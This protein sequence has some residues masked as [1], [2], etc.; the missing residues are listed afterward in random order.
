MP[1]RDVHLSAGAAAGTTYATYLAWDQPGPHVVAEAIGGV[2]GGIVGGLLPDWIDT[3]DSPHHRGE[4]HSLSIT[5]AVG[6]FVSD[7]LP[8]WQS[9]LRNK[10]EHY[11]RMH[12]ASTAG[13]PQVGYAIL[14]FLFRFLAGALAGFLAGYGSHLALDSL[15]PSS[16]PILG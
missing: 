16:L 8:E 9:S 12:A 13:L 10:A 14:E 1:N 5:G 3:P 7:Q 15:T 2:V 4:A 11:A 6:Y